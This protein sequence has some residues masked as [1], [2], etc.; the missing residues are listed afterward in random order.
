MFIRLILDLCKMQCL[1]HLMYDVK[2]TRYQFTIL[3]EQID[4]FF[5]SKRYTIIKILKIKLLNMSKALLLLFNFMLLNFDLIHHSSGRFILVEVDNKE[6]AMSNSE[7]GKTNTKMN[8]CL[9]IIS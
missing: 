1:Y 8:S 9:Y 6:T 5:S 2:L 3:L 7:I 4:T